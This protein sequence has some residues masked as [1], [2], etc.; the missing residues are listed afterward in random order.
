M[1]YLVAMTSLLAD[2]RPQSFLLRTLALLVYVEAALLLG[3]LFLSKTPSW[4]PHLVLLLLLV[5]LWGLRIDRW[6][7]KRAVVTLIG[8]GWLATLAFALWG[9]AIGWWAWCLLLPLLTAF[10]QRW[11][12]TLLLTGFLDLSNVALL[13]LTGHTGTPVPS[14][15]TLEPSRLGTLWLLFFWLQASLLGLAYLVKKRQTFREITEHNS[16][17]EVQINL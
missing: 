17:E 12:W 11:G 6:S 8:L 2:S 9:G 5:V 7:H 14:F 3:A 16:V 15:F 13:L 4:T 1:A 10:T